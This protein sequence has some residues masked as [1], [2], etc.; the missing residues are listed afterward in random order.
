MLPPGAL[1]SAGCNPGI[2][3][4][5]GP[6]HKFHQGCRGSGTPIIGD[7][8]LIF[9]VG[10]P[11]RPSWSVSRAGPLEQ[12]RQHLRLPRRRHAGPFQFAQGW[13]ICAPRRSPVLAG[14]ASGLEVPPRNYSVHARNIPKLDPL[15]LVTTP[16]KIQGSLVQEPR[17]N[18][19]TSDIKASFLEY[20]SS[21]ERRQL[22]SRQRE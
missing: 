6:R 1:L 12:A 8:P 4:R 10:A 15:F 5:T 18:K 16:P 20:S 21:P 17:K 22:A 11:R 19:A 3:T 2:Q 13:F 7:P 9:D 14:G